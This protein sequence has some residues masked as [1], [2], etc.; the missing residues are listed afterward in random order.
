MKFKQ[1]TVLLILLLISPFFL[2]CILTVKADTTQ[3]AP[4]LFFG[5]DVA[6]GSL[7]ATEQLIDK[8]SSYT[9]LFIIGC[10]GNYNL[11]RLTLISQ[12]AYDRGL[13]FIVYSDEPGYPSGQWLADAKNNWGNSFLGI[14]YCDE[15]GGKQRDQSVFP[16]VPQSYVNEAANFTYSDAAATYVNTLSRWLNTGPLAITL[17]FA[18]P[19]EYQLFTSDY[20]FYW[21]DYE[22]GYNTVF[23]EFGAHTGWANDSQQINMALCRGAATVQN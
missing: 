13:S 14:Y 19:T 8:V 9:N 4:G 2:N 16:I 5:V 18:Y 11:T 10:T 6:F 3:T 21:Y 7:S 23:D 17:N 20:A 12:Y 15:E 1:A 22:A